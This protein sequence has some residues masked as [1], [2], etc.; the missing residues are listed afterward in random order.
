MTRKDPSRIRQREDL[1]VQAVVEL[2]CEVILAVPDRRKQVGSTNPADEERVAGQYAI[3]NG[4]VR[5]FPDDDADRFRCVPRCVSSWR[6]CLG[7]TEP[8]NRAI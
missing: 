2:P 3:G 1:L 4:V 7:K 8:Q 5:V 6:S